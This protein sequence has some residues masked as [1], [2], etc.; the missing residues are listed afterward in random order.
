MKKTAIKSIK[1]IE[2]LD[3]RGIPTI[4][5]TVTLYGGGKGKAKVPSGASTGSH[6]ALE[7]RDGG[8]RYLGKGVQKA[9]KNVNVN[10][11]DL[12]KGED[13]RS[14][15][16][17]DQMMRSLDGTINKKRL[18]AN[19]ILSV[20]LACARAVANQTNT[21]LYKHIRKI[22]RL[23]MQGYKLPLPMMN[24]INGGEHADN[25]LGVQEFMII[26]KASKFSERVRKGEEIFF[27][28]KTILKK[29]KFDTFVGDEG[30]YAPQIND[31]EKV[32]KMLMS[33]SKKAGYTPGRDIVFAIDAAA[34]EFYKKGKGYDFFY[35]TKIKGKKVMSFGELKKNYEKWMKKFPLVSIEDPFTEDAWEEWKIFTKEHKKKTMIVGDDLFVTNVTRLQKGIDMKVAN[36]ILIKL[37]QIGTLSETI[38]CIK[39]AQKNKYKV[40]ISH[41]SGETADTFIADLAV[42]VN[43][44]YIKTGSLS[45]SERVEKYNRLIEIET[46]LQ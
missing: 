27:A 41:R 4:A 19:A 3:S 15:R 2:I 5:T 6:E 21:P 7:L 20:S 13:A 36:S 46:E 31:N 8:K 14:Q 28:L 39:L 35:K 42:A 1:A 9:I 17:I 23:P 32:F 18:G 16:T 10:I 44:E 11:Q 26:P 40:V 37:N 38:D 25:I 29:K 22:F 34:T 33:A 43:A 45:R 30:G 12:L 24:I